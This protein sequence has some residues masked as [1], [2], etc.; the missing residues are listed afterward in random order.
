MSTSLEILARLN[1]LS[2][3][4]ILAMEMARD[5]CYLG[6][7]SKIDEA[8]RAKAQEALD[9]LE[10]SWEAAIEA[11]EEQVD[12]WR[13]AVLIHLETAASTAKDWGSDDYER[14]ALDLVTGEDR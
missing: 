13:S 6:T 1:D 10:A 5:T 14:K 7:G 2:A 3:A 11:Y 8:K 9:E 4:S 12:G